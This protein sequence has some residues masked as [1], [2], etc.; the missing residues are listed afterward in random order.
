MTA[1]LWPI[2][3]AKMAIESAAMVK[4]AHPE[5][6]RLQLAELLDFRPDLGV[7]RL[8]EQRV[9]IL[10]A[11]AMGLLRKELFEL[12]FRSSTATAANP[13]R[14]QVLKRGIARVNTVL[15]E[16]VQSGETRTGKTRR[17]S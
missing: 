8:H 13:A 11:A 1:S 12:R 17:Q 15:H 6:E 4:P 9:V 16:R 3:L 5:L 2:P 10:S 7:I 14:I